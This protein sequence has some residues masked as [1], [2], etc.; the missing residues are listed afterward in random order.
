MKKTTAVTI[1]RCM[2]IAGLMIAACDRAHAQSAVGAQISGV[3]SD[4]SGAVVPSAQVK[5]TQTDS[6]QT[7]T[8]VSTSNGSYL[9]PNLPV[10]PYRLEVSYQGFERYVQ[11]GI[12]LTVGNDV[13]VNVNLRVGDTNQAVQ[14]SADATMVQTQD[15]AVSVVV[16]Q[17][18]IIDLPLNGR[19][20]TDLIL[21]AG[22]TTRV[23]T[24]SFGGAQALVTTK[25]YPN[26]VA[27]SVGGGQAT[28]NNYV[29]DGADNNDTFSNVNLP[30][31]FPD[32]LQEFSVQTNGLSAQFGIHPGTVVNVVTKSGTNEIHGD[33][34]EFVRNGAFNARNF[35]A[36]RR[37]SLKRNQYGGTIGGPIKKDKLFFFGG[38]QGTITRSDPTGVTSFVPTP[39]ML[40]GDFTAITSP[41]CNGGKQI[42]L[43]APF[44]NN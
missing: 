20:A 13:H 6:G 37:D 19:Q 26:S 40:A 25:N 17:R 10:G 11:S 27:V 42:A 1:L 8:T 44:T 9:L 43:K 14:V 29:M 30:F 23:P 31:P 39:Q 12:I 34:F 33:A 24:A 16:I 38:Y 21:L 28:G 4:P 2:M 18:H 5:A 41:A 7:R 22:G 36:S 15:T 32:A 35:F 3:V